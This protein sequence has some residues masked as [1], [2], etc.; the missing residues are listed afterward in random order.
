MKLDIY[1]HYTKETSTLA[2][3]LKSYRTDRSYEKITFFENRKYGITI[4]EI[5]SNQ[6]KDVLVYVDDVQIISNYEASNHTVVCLPDHIFIDCFDITRI[7]VEVIY[8]DD[9]I[10]TF[11][12]H[13]IRI[14][15]LKV[16]NQYIS[17]MLNDIENNYSY[18]LET[19]FSKGMKLSGIDQTGNRGIDHTFILL[20]DIYNIFKQVYPF[21]QNDTNKVLAENNRILRGGEINRVTPETVSWILT[22]PESM[23]QIQNKSPIVFKNKYYKVELANGADK[24]ETNDTYE[25]KVIVGFLEHIIEYLY[26]IKSN[27]ESK[28]Q[29]YREEI[30]RE[31]LLKLPSDY[32]LAYN[33]ISFFYKEIL[34]K[35]STYID[36]YHELY[37]AYHSCLR[38]EKINVTSIPRYTFIFRQRFQYRKCF[39]V[40]VKWFE[41]ANYNLK[42]FE[43]FFKLKKLSKIFEYYTLIKLQEGLIQNGG[44]LQK[45]DTYVY[46]IDQVSDINNY[47]EYTL[48][49]NSSVKI[50]IYYEPYIYRDKI[51]NELGLYCIGYNYL[52][53]MK[54]TSYW[55]PDFVLKISVNHKEA[56]FILDS[57]F[58]RFQNVKDHSM[59]Q[60]AVKYVLGIATKNHYHSQMLGLWA[61][62]PALSNG[63][64][65]LKQNK[66]QSERVSLPMI[67]IHPLRTEENTMVGLV[68]RILQLVQ[69]YM[70]HGYNY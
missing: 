18:I 36:R 20:E 27:F 15:V 50:G 49:Q 56:Y 64:L 55:T 43:Y 52:K 5:E 17:D 51:C 62:Y 30:P 38:C 60:L 59:Q 12:T 13:N 8:E 57:K 28:M 35:I 65:N 63:A 53:K 54:A 6:V 68:E 11:S 37:D 70:D 9:M 21:F 25:N 32:D 3:R 34:R 69:E 7:Q 61:V 16:T 19:C 2:L 66:V 42:T 1:D 26:D 14:A 39:E 45:T 47:Y 33:C 58:S 46:D 23:K 4:R 10:E 40:I 67:E 22:H 48:K 44:I 41:Y 31:V 29:E 24:C